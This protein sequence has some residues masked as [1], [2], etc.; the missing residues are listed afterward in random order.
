[1]LTAYFDESGTHLG[2]KVI[3]VAGYLASDEQWLKFKDEWSQVFSDYEIDYFHMTD[4]ESGYKQF[5][6][7]SKHN[8]QRLL[9][10]LLTFL[11][12][13]ARFGIGAAFYISS[14][15]ELVAEGYGDE[16]GSPYYWCAAICL[17]AVKRWA[18]KQSCQ[19]PITLVF[20]KGAKES[21]EFQKSFKKYRTTQDYKDNYRISSL[22]FLDKRQSLPLQ[23]ADILAYETWKYLCNELAANPRRPRWSMM[24]LSKIPFKWYYADKD[25]LRQVM[26]NRRIDSDTSASST[27]AVKSK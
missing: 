17:H 8:K 15:D 23:A 4:F 1:M 27:V 5:K 12:I 16:V 18:N 2:S 10:R 3:V 19:Y 24:E 21:G 7:L 26:L 13:R 11:R 14:Y 22:T 25:A 9:D 6:S 20:E